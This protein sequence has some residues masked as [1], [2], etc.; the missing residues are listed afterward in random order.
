LIESFYRSIRDKTAEPI[1]YKE[2]LLTS[3]IMDE[4]FLQLNEKVVAA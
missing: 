3:W 4:I 2:L 1:P